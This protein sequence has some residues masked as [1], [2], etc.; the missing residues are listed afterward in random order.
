MD[1][2]QRSVVIPTLEVVIDRAARW[3]VL[4][5]LRPLATRAEYIPH[6]IDHRSLVN[7]TALLPLRL[8]AGIIEPISAHSSSV[9]SLG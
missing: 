3:K 8:A 4:R 6:P 2:R 9:T 7:L 5:Q 1:T